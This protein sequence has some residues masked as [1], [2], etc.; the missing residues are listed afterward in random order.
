VAGRAYLGGHS[1][2]EDTV[3]DIR[4]RSLAN[5]PRVF[6]QLGSAIDLLDIFD[7]SAHGLP[8]RRIATFQAREITFLDTQIPAWLSEALKPTAYPIQSLLACFHRKQPLPDPPSP[9]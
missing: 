6:D 3:R 7:N 2:S 9:N 8:P 4:S 5:L 1:G